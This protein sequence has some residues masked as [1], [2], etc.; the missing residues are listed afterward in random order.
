M[1][2]KVSSRCRLWEGLCGSRDEDKMVDKPLPQ[3]GRLCRG[4]CVQGMIADKA[5]SNLEV[6]RKQ[7]ERTEGKTNQESNWTPAVTKSPTSLKQQWKGNR[8]KAKRHLDSKSSQMP[9]ELFA[10]HQLTESLPQQR[11]FCGQWW[12][13]LGQWQELAVLISLLFW[14]ARPSCCQHCSSELAWRF[15]GKEAVLL[16]TENWSFYL[17][18]WLAGCRQVF[19]E[20]AQ[21]QFRIGTYSFLE[22][23]SK[24][25]PRR[26]TKESFCIGLEKQLF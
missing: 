6:D 26:E 12:L 11:H 15:R 16:G 14:Q 9:L 1:A 2:D 25:G 5:S 4:L 13:E 7:R 10:P 20:F 17:W 22:T 18:S 3:D 23:C 21:G 19:V 8:G 24:Q